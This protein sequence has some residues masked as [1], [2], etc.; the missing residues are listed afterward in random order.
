MKAPVF[1]LVR[2]VSLVIWGAVLLL[3]ILLLL[4]GGLGVYLVLTSASP[5]FMGP[6]FF[7][8]MLALYCGIP[9]LLVAALGG[10]M[11]DRAARSQP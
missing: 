4:L 5:E 11:L 6:G 9:G 3:G 8:L 1:H 10:W 7:G 2:G